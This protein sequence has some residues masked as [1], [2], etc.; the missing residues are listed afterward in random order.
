V[1]SYLDRLPLSAEEKAK[2]KD[3]AAETPSALLSMIQANP[4]SFE[5]YLGV[6]RTPEIMEMIDNLVSHNERQVLK[7]PLTGFRELGA[8]VG[9]TSPAPKQPNYDLEKRNQLFEELKY[10]QSQDSSS[11]NVKQRITKL[12][13]QLN[14]LFSKEH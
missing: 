10:W 8:I 3:L 1:D 6:K 4:K 13:E 12:T 5:D 9:K 14:E 11:D 2:L 7:T